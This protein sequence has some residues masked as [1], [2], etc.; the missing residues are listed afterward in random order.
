[1]L[2]KIFAFSFI[3]FFSRVLGLVRDAL[4]A[5]HLGRKAIG[6]ISCGISSA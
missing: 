4:V 2:K 5:Y 1:M 3:T 6:R